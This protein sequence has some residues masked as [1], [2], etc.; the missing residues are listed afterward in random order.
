[1]F[2]A[3]LP[4]Q[5]LLLLNVCETKLYTFLSQSWVIWAREFTHWHVI[6]TFIKPTN[7]D[8][9]KMKMSTYLNE[10]ICVTLKKKKHVVVTYTNTILDLFLFFGL[11]NVVDSYH[12][13]RKDEYF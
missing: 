2:L 11:K 4:P 7:Q 10:H 13:K 12:Y 1:M 5:K 8:E 6:W 3:P 9:T